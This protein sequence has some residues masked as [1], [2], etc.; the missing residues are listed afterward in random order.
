M[1]KE[2]LREGNGKQ[3]YG[4]GGVYG[5]WKRSEWILIL[6][7]WAILGFGLFG[8]NASMDNW[9][10]AALVGFLE[11]ILFTMIDK[12]VPVVYSCWALDPERIIIE[13]TFYL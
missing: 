9:V 3:I 13:M 2:A 4:S 12:V 8:P 5:D 10:Q 11:W 6:S 7:L 1:W